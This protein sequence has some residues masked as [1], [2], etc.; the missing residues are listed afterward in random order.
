VAELLQE[1]YGPLI[2]SGDVDDVDAVLAAMIRTEDQLRPLHGVDAVAARA[3]LALSRAGHV[4][5]TDT[6]HAAAGRRAMDD[7]RGLMTDLLRHR[8]GGDGR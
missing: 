2:K 4:L 5:F 8:G 1:C 6:T 3:I 7:S